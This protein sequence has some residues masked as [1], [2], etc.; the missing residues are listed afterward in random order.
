MREPI[1]D[2]TSSPEADG[3]GRK[4]Q[5]ALRDRKWPGRPCIHMCDSAMRSAPAL[6][7]VDG[8]FNVPCQ[9]GDLD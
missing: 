1:A 9:S 7:Q 3:M 5:P 4:P 8:D 6:K 2:P